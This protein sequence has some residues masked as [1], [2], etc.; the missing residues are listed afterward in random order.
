M[1]VVNGFF[2]R[3]KSL[4]CF[5]LGL[6]SIV[7]VAT[8]LSPWLIRPQWLRFERWMQGEV[9]GVALHQAPWWLRFDGHVHLL[10]VL[11]LGLCLCA[12]CRLLSWPSWWALLGLIVVIGVDESLQAFSP[13]VVLT[14]WMQV[15]RW[16]QCC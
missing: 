4:R 13:T 11:L 5:V 16:L 6:L 14:G 12:W 1:T 2:N 9:Y 7:V 10:M 15:I 3:R 8:G